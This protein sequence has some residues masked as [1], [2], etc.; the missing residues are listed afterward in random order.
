[1]RIDG[2]TNKFKSRLVAHEFN[3][4]KGID[5]FDTSFLA[6]KVSTIHTLI[7]ITSIH[8]LISHQMDVKIAVLIVE[9]IYMK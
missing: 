7:A 9:E 3:L 5:Y 6:A 2:T 8:N 4:R 1:L